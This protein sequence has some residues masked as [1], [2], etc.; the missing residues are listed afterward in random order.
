[1]P[2]VF[3]DSTILAFS[4][5]RCSYRTI[6]RLPMLLSALWTFRCSFPCFLK[7]EVTLLP[8]RPPSQIA[9]R[10]AS[11]LSLIRPFPLLTWLLAFTLTV[12]ATLVATIVV[13]QHSH[14]PMI[15]DVT[16]KSIFHGSTSVISR[17]VPRCS[18][19]LTSFV[20]ISAG[21]TK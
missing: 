5:G 20:I 21:S 11:R 15:S 19:V 7:Q 10:L 14:G 18:I 13:Q 17:I 8:I 6:L 12:I 9:Q 3:Q 1:M 16:P 4:I 2:P